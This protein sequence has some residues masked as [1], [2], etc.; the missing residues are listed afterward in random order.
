MNAVTANRSRHL[1][2]F[3]LVGHGS[4]AGF[5]AVEGGDELVDHGR[6]EPDELSGPPGGGGSACARHRGSEKD[7]AAL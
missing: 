7:D 6:L 5:G 2:R 1:H 3:D 4:R